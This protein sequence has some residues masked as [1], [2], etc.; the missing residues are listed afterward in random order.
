MSKETICSASWITTGSAVANF[1]AGLDSVCLAFDG[2]LTLQDM[3]KMMIAFAET[4]SE[5]GGDD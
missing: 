2:D 5:G 4:L 3:K 1:V